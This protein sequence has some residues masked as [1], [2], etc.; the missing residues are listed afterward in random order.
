MHALHMLSSGFFSEV[1]TVS[2][3]SRLHPTTSYNEL[4]NLPCLQ[5]F[6]AE[7]WV[8]LEMFFTAFFT[9]EV[10]VKMRLD[11]TSCFEIFESDVSLNVGHSNSLNNNNT[12]IYYNIL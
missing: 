10:I 3:V 4:F 5:L 11:S 2:Y 6:G 12:I 8:I 1:K 9:L 7:V